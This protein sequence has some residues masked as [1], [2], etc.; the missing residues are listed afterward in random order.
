MKR[1]G[2]YTE[3]FRNDRWAIFKAQG[4]LNQVL[5]KNTITTETH[6]F[7]RYTHK[8]AFFAETGTPHSHTMTDEELIDALGTDLGLSWDMVFCEDKGAAVRDAAREYLAAR[9]A[10][11]EAGKKLIGLAMAV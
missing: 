9:S 7:A 1:H 8:P 3:I 2:T 10:K 11:E 4:G 5:A 6:A